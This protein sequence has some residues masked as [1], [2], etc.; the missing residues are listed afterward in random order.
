MS[1]AFLFLMFFAQHSTSPS[2]NGGPDYDREARYQELMKH[3]SFDEEV[4]RAAAIEEHQ[5]VSRFNHLI[6]VLIEFS[7]H[8]NKDHS[9]N[10]KK[11]KAVKK[12]W[13]DLEKTDSWFRLDEPESSDPRLAA[14]KKK[15]RNKLFRQ[16]TDK[17]PDE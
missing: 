17:P 14:Q 5:F 11:V 1:F 4:K 16:E 12:A 8:Y 3:D 13:H 10:I 7:D 2:Q 6:R 15:G 9:V